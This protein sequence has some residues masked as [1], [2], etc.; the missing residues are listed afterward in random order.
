MTKAIVLSSG[1]LDSATTMAVAKDQGYELYSL[2]FDYGQKHRAELRAA[3]QLAHVNHAVHRLVDVTAISGFMRSALTDSDIAV[4][5]YSGQSGI[6]VTYVP[7]RNTIFLSVAL[8]Y[9]E[10]LGADVIFMGC[11][12]ADYMAYPDCQADY[13]DAFQAMANLALKRA[14]EGQPV[15]IQAPL[16]NLSKQNIIELGTRLKV[17]YSFTVSC[18]RSDDQGRACGRCDACTFRKE[19]FKKAGIADPTRYESCCG[20]CPLPQP[21]S[22]KR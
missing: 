14:R 5:D 4:P 10:T 16:M 9:A 19:G 8:G 17:D 12:L 20:K 2:T 18:Y 15:L 11:N 3:E 13:I 22:R 1:G 21:L 6:P 7:A